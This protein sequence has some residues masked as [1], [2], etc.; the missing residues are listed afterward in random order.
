MSIQK[1]PDNNGIMHT[2]QSAYRLLLNAMSFPGS[3]V[4]LQKQ[5]KSINY[6][7]KSHSCIL[8][9]GLMLLDAEVS[10][11]ILSKQSDHVSAM[12]KQLTYSRAVLLDEA[13]YIFI[14]EDISDGDIHQAFT[15]SKNGSLLSPHQSS[16]LIMHVPSISAG[17]NLQ[18]TGPG[19]EHSR[20]IGI[21]GAKKWLPLRKKK[22][23]EYPLGIDLILLDSLHDMVCLPRTTQIQLDQEL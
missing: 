9:L 1:N 18:L 8:L 10:F 16:T 11:C 5:A 15:K 12:L 17:G 13:D 14:L 4:S 6:I 7:S 2:I 21:E 23:V 20:S 22:N 3:I 19:I